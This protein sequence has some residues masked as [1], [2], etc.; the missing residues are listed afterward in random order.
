MLLL[1]QN[2]CPPEGCFDDDESYR[3]LKACRTVRGKYN[4]SGEQREAPHFVLLRGDKSGYIA[5][6]IQPFRLCR[7]TGD[8]RLRYRRRSSPL[9]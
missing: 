3:L 8:A 4:W 1:S 9:L 2:R 5:E 7:I 6:V